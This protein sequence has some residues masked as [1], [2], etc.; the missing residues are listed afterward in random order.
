MNKFEVKAVA[1]LANDII[2]S[3]LVD[4]ETLVDKDTDSR[5]SK[6]TY[7]SNVEHKLRERG[8]VTSEIK[9]VLRLARI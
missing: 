2:G 1:I 8:M 7:P 6:F 5:A 9:E 3:D 4:F